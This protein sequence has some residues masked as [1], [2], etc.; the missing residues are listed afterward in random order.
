V[1]VPGIR[2]EEDRR[3]EP[4]AFGDLLHGVEPHGHRPR[5]GVL[6]VDELD[7]VALRDRVRRPRRDEPRR[8]AGEGVD[9]E[10]RLLADRAAR[11]HRERGADH[12]PRLLLERHL[13]DEVVHALGHGPA[14]VLVGIQ[15]P[16][17]VEVLEDEAVHLQRPDHRVR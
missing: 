5:L 8:A 4:P 14:P 3:A 2:D 12:Q 11:A 10:D 16:V 6:A 13:R 15:R 17:L 9:A 1:V 7:D